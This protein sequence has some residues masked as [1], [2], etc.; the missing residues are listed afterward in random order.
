MSLII[1]LI[2]PS[3]S[4]RGFP[5][6][7]RYLKQ[8][9]QD[10]FRTYAENFD[11]MLISAFDLHFDY[12][13]IADIPDEKLIFID[14][15]G[16]ES[17]EWDDDSAIYLKQLARPDEPW[18]QDHMIST[19]SK[20]P[21][22][23]R[24]VFVNYDLEVDL[25]DQISS[26]ITQFRPISNAKKS[27]L[28]KEEPEIINGVSTGRMTKLSITL[29]K[30]PNIA[31]DLRMFDVIGVTEKSLGSSYFERLTN[32][33]FLRGLLD[34]LGLTAPVHVFG[35][36]DPLSVRIYSMA[37]ADIFD[38]LTWLRFAYRDNRCVYLSNDMLEESELTE[39]LSEAR[40]AVY[41]RNYGELKLLQNELRE[42]R[43]TGDVTK[44]QLN[45]KIRNRVLRALEVAK[46]TKNF[47]TFVGK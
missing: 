47:Q 14:S 9:T 31:K 1:P 38:G 4:S 26:A 45:E 36:L 40:D 46:S 12:V 28:I 7:R 17:R 10:H 41:A 43:R 19:I 6:E 5:Q 25:A 33:A 3:F 8:V 18:T 2:V 34:K 32:L 37:G 27:F 29:T 23:S 11:A 16:Y 20:L 30:L 39:N 21:D 15:G 44:L 13:Q 35:A 22:E 42:Y 24:F